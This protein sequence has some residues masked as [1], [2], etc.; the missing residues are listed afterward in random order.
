[1]EKSLEINPDNADAHLFLGLIYEREKR[2]EDAEKQF[3][4]V[5]ELVPDYEDATLGL[6]RIVKARL[7]EEEEKSKFTAW[8]EM[9]IEAAED[10]IKQ[11]DYIKASR[12]WYTLYDD[13]PTNPYFTYHLGEVL[14]WM[15]RPHEAIYFLKMT[16]ELQPDHTDAMLRLGFAQMAL[17]HNKMAENLFNEIIRIDGDRVDALDGL[18]R[19]LYVQARY[20]AAQCA[21]LRRFADGDPDYFIYKLYSRVLKR[22]N[23]STKGLVVYAQERETDLVIKTVTAQRNTFVSAVS[24]RLPI[25]DRL[26]LS[27][28][29][30]AGTTRERNL[31]NGTNNLFIPETIVNGVAD[32]QVHPKVA[33]AGGLGVQ[34]GEDT[35]DPNFKLGHRMRMLPSGSISYNGVKESYTL[36]A[37]I[38][39]LIVKLFGTGRST[40]MPRDT[41]LMDAQWNLF[42]NRI[43]L[44]TSNFLRYYHDV[45]SNRQWDTSLWAET[46]Y[47]RFGSYFFLRYSAHIGG[48]TT[49]E[50]D[51]PSYKRQWDHTV[52]FFFSRDTVLNTEIEFAY[53]HSW[54]WNRKLNQPVNTVITLTK[55]FRGIDK[56][57][58]ELRQLY[59]PNIQGI[60]RSDIYFDSTNYKSWST[61][62]S[63]NLT[64]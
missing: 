13:D 33:L 45:K 31:V 23:F 62:G 50:T 59:R 44:N 53:L 58:L 4:L 19:S 48:Y 43:T 25:S 14:G 63:L 47:P 29:F 18:T 38:D 3:E 20:G 26:S 55:L 10:A 60:F 42:E 34:H 21:A 6:E 30:Q 49:Y 61:K 16:L 22:T 37:Y 57:Y 2:L 5:L 7:P 12:A 54:Q 41:Y 8:Q 15:S 46:G 40:L 11:R 28:S 17:G 64:F 36:T 27:G 52:T 35:G 56:L 24:A 39:T 9:M 32:W 1:M 51:Y